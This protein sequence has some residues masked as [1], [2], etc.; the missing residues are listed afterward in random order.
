M[1]SLLAKEAA[2]QWSIEHDIDWQLPIR[3]PIWFRRRTYI[4]AI[5]QFY[6]GE[7][8][9]QRVC[10]RL[11]DDLQ[12]LDIEF[13]WLTRSDLR[14]VFYP[15]VGKLRLSRNDEPALI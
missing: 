13:Y 5:S 9:T 11:L 15:R 14:R 12:H 2:D 4:K 7:R 3:T 8:A 1:D 6:H 10:N